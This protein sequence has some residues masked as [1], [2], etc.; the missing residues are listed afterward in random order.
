M[1]PDVFDPSVND[2]KQAG[3]PS[4][5]QFA[6]GDAG[7]PA[8]QGVRFLQARGAECLRVGR[9]AVASRAAVMG[10]C[11]RA[12]AATMITGRDISWMYGRADT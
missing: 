5:G 8:G 7:T 10:R 12:S 9:Q 4:A 3:D 11:R 2:G 6:V 1:R